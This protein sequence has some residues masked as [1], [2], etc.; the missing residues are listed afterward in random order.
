VDVAHA[1]TSTTH[2]KNAAPVTDKTTSLVK[3]S[4]TKG[5]H[6]HLLPVLIG[7]ACGL[8]ML[9]DVIANLIPHTLCAVTGGT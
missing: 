3:L 7:N 8:A 5:W 4:K 2:C 9:S 1:R 6:M